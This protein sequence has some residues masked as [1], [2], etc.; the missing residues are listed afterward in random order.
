M[1]TFIYIHTY[2]IHISVDYSQ[3]ISVK[4]V[5]KKNWLSPQ[6]GETVR[7]IPFHYLQIYLAEEEFAMSISI[8]QK[9]FEQQLIFDHKY[10]V[11]G[12]SLLIPGYWF[13]FVNLESHVIFPEAW[14]MDSRSWDL[15]PKSR[16]PSTSPVSFVP[17]RSVIITK[18]DKKLEQNG[19][20]L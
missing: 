3:Y 8:W 4:K 19:K 12:L 14:F 16:F 2:Y 17:V 6:L 11:I 20:K 7:S 15:G 18:C 13:C 10:Q 5:D 1:Y 9:L